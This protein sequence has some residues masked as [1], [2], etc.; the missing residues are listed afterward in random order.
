MPHPSVPP[1]SVL[2]CL[3]FA[4]CSTEAD[5]FLGLGHLILRSCTPVLEGLGYMAKIRLLPKI[6]NQKC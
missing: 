1:K 5:L 2:W 3:V 4:F 6:V